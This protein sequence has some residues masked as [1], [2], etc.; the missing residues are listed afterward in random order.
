MAARR[1][2]GRLRGHLSPAAEPQES[3]GV[4]KWVRGLFGQDELEPVPVVEHA[5]FPSHGVDG[6]HVHP[7]IC[8]TAVQYPLPTTPPHPASPHPDP[9]PPGGTVCVRTA[10]SSSSTPPT[11][12]IPTVRTC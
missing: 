7:S 2:L 10:L 5:T 12:T 1:R 11:R 4:L 3:A 9:T 8:K 6:G